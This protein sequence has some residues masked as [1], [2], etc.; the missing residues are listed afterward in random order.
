LVV[1]SL[2]AMIHARKYAL[3]QEASKAY[4]DRVLD[5]TMPATTDVEKAQILNKTVLQLER[6]SNVSRAVISITREIMD[7]TGLKS[8][9]GVAA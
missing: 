7:I 8:K 4:Y 9:R 3:V 1:P 2:P 5:H 6:D